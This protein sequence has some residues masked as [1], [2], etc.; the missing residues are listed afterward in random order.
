MRAN[1]DRAIAS[2]LRWE[3]G[4][5]VRPNEPGGAVNMG[6][7]LQAF[8]EEHPEATLNDL[9]H[10]SQDEAKRIYAK[11]YAGKIGFDDLPSGYDA[12]MLHGA[13]MFGVNGIKKLDAE[14]KG[15]LGYLVVLMMHAKMHREMNTWRFMG[16]WSDRFK[17]VYELG[18]ELQQ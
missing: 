4:S 3:G 17:A 8:R 18:K 5:A 2:V 9:L 1:W 15:D 7:S 6:V 12:A 13:V 11:N 14:A 16:G 10:M